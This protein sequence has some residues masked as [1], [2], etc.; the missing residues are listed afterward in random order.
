MIK[1]TLYIHIG[2]GKTGTTTIQDTCE[3]NCSVLRDIYELE[4]I[5]FGHKFSKNSTNREAEAI[6][7][8]NQNLNELKNTIKNG[9]SKKYLIS[10]E[11]FPGEKEEEIEFIK[12]LL[13]DVCDVKII[14]YLRRQDTLV[15]SWY[16]QMV[17][18]GQYSKTITGQINELYASDF[19][20]YEKTLE[21]W[22]ELFGHENI[23]VNVFPSKEDLITNFFEKN[24]DININ[25]KELN[26][27]QSSNIGLT[28]EQ[29][30]LIKNILPNTEKEKHKHL[31]EEIIKPI[32]IDFNYTN[33]LISP[34]QQKE[35]LDAFKYSNN[36]VAKKYLN[37]EKLFE[38]PVIEDERAWQYPDIL[39][40]GYIDAILKSK[41]LSLKTKNFIK[42]R[43]NLEDKKW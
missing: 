13:Q 25:L 8:V 34:S 22:S 30:I 7:E 23:F 17:K 6:L 24:L 36:N 33:S 31:I 29:L 14:V 38:D 43:I 28:P 18:T 15:Y 41:K 42:G 10:S 35:L 39:N 1:K 20:D 12:K 4:Y 11:N 27:K 40:N 26:I 3:R 37:R 2:A 16:T 21:P 5:K 9:E 32:H 19:L